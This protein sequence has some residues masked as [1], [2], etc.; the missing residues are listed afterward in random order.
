MVRESLLGSLNIQFVL[1][2]LCL[3]YGAIQQTLLRVVNT[4]HCYNNDVTSTL[5]VASTSTWR[6]FYSSLTLLQDLHSHTH[7]HAR[8][9]P[10]QTFNSNFPALR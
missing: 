5:I 10:A 7:T 6:P 2:Q 3:E 9:E 8:E 1:Q 4:T